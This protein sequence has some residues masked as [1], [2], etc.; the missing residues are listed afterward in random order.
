[1]VTVGLSLTPTAV[2]EG[3]G[4][5]QGCAMLTGA[6]P[7]LGCPV[8]VRLYTEDETA[9]SKCMYEQKVK[10]VVTVFSSCEIHTIECF[11]AQSDEN[12]FL[13]V[14]LFFLH[15]VRTTNILH[16]PMLYS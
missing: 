3:A 8:M 1:M 14:M 11:V 10:L 7:T 9:T 13:H 2:D 4:S 16:F 5:V 15:T 6:N 12:M